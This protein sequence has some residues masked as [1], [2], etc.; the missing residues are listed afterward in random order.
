MA[1]KRPTRAKYQ[2]FFDPA[3]L[4]PQFTNVG[5]QGLL[6]LND[7]QGLM[8]VALYLTGLRTADQIRVNLSASGYDDKTHQL[9]LVTQ[10]KTT[11]AGAWE[12]HLVDGVP[13]HPR[14][15]PHCI[16]KQLKGRR[17][18]SV[19]TFYWKETKSG[20]APITAE[21]AGHLAEMVMR[22]AGIPE[23]FTA[24]SLRGAGATKALE[25]RID[26]HTVRRTFHW[27]TGSSILDQCYN[28][29]RSSVSLAASVFAPSH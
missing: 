2:E 21:W 20:R 22:K 4:V 6:P 9:R 13:E 28:R 18:A 15:C 24:H 11:E 3:V 10:L 29:A 23:K 1:R 12:T 16:F 27:S 26:E 7:L 17:P 25:Q 19:K 5:P 14:L 8:I